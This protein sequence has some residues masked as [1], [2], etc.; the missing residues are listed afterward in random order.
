MNL[1]LDDHQKN[2]AIKQF[3][4]WVDEKCWAQI[5]RYSNLFHDCSLCNVL[6]CKYLSTASSCREI[7]GDK[8][9]YNLKGS[10]ARKLIK[11]KN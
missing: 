7:C 5:A 10:K 8:I 9:L 6:I 1:A 2:F 4:I 3:V 11:N